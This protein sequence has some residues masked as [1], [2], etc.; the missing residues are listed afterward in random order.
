MKLR[1]YILLCLSVGLMSSCN[2]MD[3][4][5]SDYYELDE[6]QQSY[7]RVK[8]FVTNVY[9]YLPSDFCSLDGAMQDAA[10]DDAV[11]VYETSNIQ[12]FVNG[13]WSAN[14][15]ID[16]QYGK[17]YNGIH[18]ANFYLE[19]LVGLDFKDWEYGDDYESW[20]HDYKYHEYE[21]RF[22]R[23]YF[24]FELV[25]RYQRVP[26]ITKVLSI[27]EVNNSKPV[28]SPQEIFDFIIS[29]C[30]EIKDELPV[31]YNDFKDKEYGRI[32]K[33]AVLALKARASLYA[34]SPLYSESSQ[35]KWVAAAKAAYEIIGQHSQL[36]Y[37]LDKSF[38]N[39][40][41]PKNNMSKEVILARPT[42]QNNG[43]ESSN[44][45]MGVKS[46]KTSTCPTENLASAFDMKDGTP[47]DWN[48]PAHA[49]NPYKNRDPRFYLTIVHNEMIWPAKNPVEI[50]EGGAN[51][52]PLNN[53]TTTGYYL[54]KYVNNEISFEP[55]APTAKAHHN[56]VLFRYAEVLLNYA[57]AMVNAYNDPT[58]KDDVCMMSAEEA[59][60]M[61]RN[62]NGVKMPAIT[63]KNA[64][65][66][67]ACVKHER[68]VELAFEGHRFWDL[69]RW[70]SL[71]ESMDIY[72]VKVEKDDDGAMH[73]TPFLME[74][75][76]MDEKLYFYPIANTEMFKNDN[77][78]QNPGW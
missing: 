45:P 18:D 2:F 55:G 47:F 27:D 78:V 69:R 56:W 8:Q 42:G 50:W 38:A 10:T 36:G 33:G 65:E 67:L 61:V 62:R 13:T 17:Y 58:Y 14:Y 7:S 30:D 46:G 49:A 37:D 39:L 75:R 28:D 74:T 23:A 3:C 76:D 22:L 60:N 16:D 48:N 72:A 77:L 34:A 11:H 59:L 43:F 41:G 63:G 52:L 32:T 54:R 35:S 5:E 1:K 57:E 70:K 44:F 26:L 31:N 53:A 29:E 68:R 15:T 19:N 20:M 66:F 9:G 6:I 21:I 25:R 4:D 64:D 71:E 40:F 51:A 73:Y 12:R 24:Y